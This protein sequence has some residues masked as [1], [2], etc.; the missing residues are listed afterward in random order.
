VI[1]SDG[2]HIYNGYCKQLSVEAV[3]QAETVTV[4]LRSTTLW[5]FKHNDA[6]WDGAELS[7]VEEGHPDEVPQPAWGYPVVAKGSKIGVHS[8]RPAFVRDWAKQLVSAGTYFPVVK[9]V[10]DIDWLVE[11]KR[12]SPKTITIARLHSS[13]ESCHEINTGGDLNDLADRL[14]DRVLQKIAMNPTLKQIDYWEICNEPVPDSVPSAVRL[15]TVM[16]RCMELAEANGL[17]LGLFS[18]CAGT[19]EWDQM[20]AMV[21]TGVFG[22]ARRGG[23]ILCLHEGVFGND[24]VDKWWGER[25]PGSPVVEGA[26][27]LCFRYRYLYHLLKG[28]NE[29]IPLVVSEIVYGGGYGVYATETIVERARWYDGEARK[30]YYVL[31]HLPFTVGPVGGWEQQD[32]SPAYPELMRY[33]ISVKDLPNGTP[34][35]EQ[36]PLPKRGQPRVQYGRTYVLLPPDADAS[37]SRAAIDAV[38][39]THRYTVGSSADDAGIGDLDNRR[40]I[41]VNP[42]KWPG[43]LQAFFETYYPGVQYTPVEAATPAELARKLKQL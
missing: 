22:K 17:K 36:P 2:W 3:A 18:L 33:M 41:A 27:A 12:E 1:W 13:F 32:Y 14:V 7:V 42:G 29:V 9:S 10:D 16:F 39:D 15:C 8:L 4:F 11:L 35:P 43:D 23:H 31:G 19:P 21:N 34:I 38:W 24:P 40:V 5:P 20:V 28:R 6:Y 25:I 26:G 37:W 30:D